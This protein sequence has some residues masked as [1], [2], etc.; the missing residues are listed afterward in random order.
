M[1]KILGLIVSCAL[2]FSAY[3]AELHGVKLEDKI[4]VEGKDLVLNGMG[5]RT[6]TRFGLKI[7][8]Y[9]MGLY[10]PEKKS[11]TDEVLKLDGPKVYKMTFVRQ[12]DSKDVENGWRTGFKNNCGDKCKA[13]E[14][15]L[16][17]F[18][19][20]MSDMRNKHTI[21]VTVYK[22]KVEVDAKGRRPKAVTIEGEDFAR[23][24][25][26]IWLGNPPNEELKT[27]ILGKG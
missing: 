22:D 1:V 26:K 2:S 14:D 15:K 16:R 23:I 9:I 13:N 5:L 11:S 17:E 21:T 27:G 10:L 6:V 4:T 12:V 20:A 8:V 19:S 7:K 24:V 25:E 3:S 18:N